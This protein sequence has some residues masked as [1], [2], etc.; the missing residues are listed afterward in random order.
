[1]KKIL[2]ASLLAIALTGCAVQQGNY[3][4]PTEHGVTAPSM[5]SVVSASVDVLK[6][7]YPPAKSALKLNITD[8]AIS[9]PLITALRQA[10]YAVYEIHPEPQFKSTYEEEK[11]AIPESAQALQYVFDV[12]DRGQA[13]YQL[14]MSVE[15]TRI[16]GVFKLEHGQ[17]KQVAPWSVF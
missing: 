5:D 14:T 10:G 9:T 17:Y 6:Q 3:V 11:P 16:A 4:Q 7:K 12:L 13:L 8:D 1:M 2:I 15:K